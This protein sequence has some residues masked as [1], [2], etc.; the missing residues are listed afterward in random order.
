[1]KN[2]PR[3]KKEF[4]SRKKFCSD[5]CKYWYNSI[6][7]DEE[8]YSG[9]APFR[10]RNENYFSMVTGYERAKSSSTQGKR[11]GHMVMGAMLA[12]INVTTEDWVLVNEENLKIHFSHPE[13]FRPSYIRLGD[14]RRIRKENI[15]TELGIKLNF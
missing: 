15:E 1:M 4:D 8:K 5:S 6:K 3:C 9:L 12:M 14:G 2:C 11:C 7:K 10:K 13:Y